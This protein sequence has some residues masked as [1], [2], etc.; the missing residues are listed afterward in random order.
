MER[1]NENPVARDDRAK[2]DQSR[3]NP[4]LNSEPQAPRQAASAWKRTAIETLS[5]L[6]IKF[7]A[8]FAGSRQPLKL[9]IHIDII[10]AA[11]AIDPANIGR[12]LKL[13]T[14]HVG[15]LRACV[16]GRAR[17]GLDSQPFG[18]VSASEAKHAADVLAKVKGK[19]Q[20][21]PA[22]SSPLASTSAPPRLTLATLKEA[23]K[24]KSTSG[25]A[26]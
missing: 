5:S 20:P 12:A 22:L 1:T 2:G 24:R 10:A 14:G 13:Y 3:K 25:G 18:T 21:P 11:P 23:A 8:C 16:E 15:Y 6:R 9:K 19:S 26:A 4:P 7:P 17:I